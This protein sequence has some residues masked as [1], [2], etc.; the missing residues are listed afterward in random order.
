MNATQLLRLWELQHGSMEAAAKE[1]FLAS[2]EILT[3]TSFDGTTIV[4][5]I[6]TSQNLGQL[7]SALEAEIGVGRLTR[8]ALPEPN[9]PLRSKSLPEAKP[10]KASSRPRSEKP[11]TPDT[12]LKLWISIH[13]E[14]EPG[15]DTLWKGRAELQELIH[16]EDAVLRQAFSSSEELV[17]I[18][19]AARIIEPGVRKRLNEAK[20]IDLAR[21]DD[22]PDADSVPKPRKAS[23]EPQD[24]SPKPDAAK[25]RSRSPSPT[26]REKMKPDYTRKIASGN[27]RGFRQA[28]E[29]A[30]NW[31]RRF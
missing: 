22:A 25:R 28:E 27:G 2:P 23:H 8:P 29:D 19:R 18:M 7:V 15:L 21:P 6:R 20:K 24:V 3:I 17:E 26:R 9:F 30:K 12:L 10:E 13:G 11:H 14:M 5:M 31:R 4:R 1:I 16:Y